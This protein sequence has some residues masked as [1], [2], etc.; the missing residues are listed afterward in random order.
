MTE[1]AFVYEDIEIPEM[2]LTEMLDESIRHH[3]DKT[4]MTFGELVYT[5]EEMDERIDRVARGLSQRGVKKGDRVAL[6]LPNCP[7]YPVSY[8][9]ILRLG[10][11]VVQVN[12]MYKPPELLHVLND[13]GVSA[14]VI[15]DSLQPLLDAVR[16]NTQ[17]ESVVDVS[18]TE[19]S[20]FDELLMEEGVSAPRVDIDP[21]EDVA[22]IQYTGGTT[23]RSKG[24]ML[25]H[26]NLVANTLQSAA[27]QSDKTNRGNERVLTIAP[28]FHVYGMT[29]AMN[30]TFYLG[31]NVILVP[32]FEV[33]N[34]ASIIE[35]LKPTSFP[36]V[37]TMYMALMEYYQEKNF[38]TS[39]LNVLTSGSAPLPVEVMNQFHS[40]TGA[41]IAEGYG[42]S[43]ASP[44]THRNP[45]TGL[46][47]RGSIGVTL[48]NTEARIVDIATGENT[49]PTGDVG[50]LI[51]RGPQIMKGYYGMPEETEQTLR[52]G[53]LYTGDLANVD[54]DGYFY[55]VGRKKEMILASGFNVYPIEVEGVLYRHP[56]VQEA[57]VIG[58]PDSY[59]GENV[60]AVIVK[61]EDSNTTEDEVIEFC[62][63][64]LSSYKVPKLIYFVEELPKSAVGK[65]LKRELVEEEQRLK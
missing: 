48:P 50:E 8:F 40:I 20:S 16:S 60:K 29:S 4:A 6:M 23:G 55:I 33:E 9:A 43:E 36:G 3:R 56:S 28:L 21:K 18:L 41:S 19:P 27:T 46:Q 58:V 14:M 10:A 51:I 63:E 13:S 30:L 57:A 2:S 17:V 65:I 45:V 52:N 54:E 26:Y 44:V 34:V 64:N 49:M 47:K 24:A 62:Q 59:R 32:K 7:Q 37:P 25:T 22:V 61:R 11:S 35:R 15:L 38:D 53:W 31:G 39:S 42:L 12:P 1:K 5:Y